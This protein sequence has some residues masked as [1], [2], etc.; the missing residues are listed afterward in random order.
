MPVTTLDPKTALVIIDLQKGI[1]SLPVPHIQEV[2]SHASALT[3]GFRQHQLPVVL[4]NV[5]D[6]PP[7]RTEYSRNA[8]PFPPDFAEIIADLQPQP[9]DH[10]VT[11]QTPGAFTNTDLEAYLKKMGITQIVIAGVATSNGVEATARHAFEL[12]FNISFAIDAIADINAEAHT[13]SITH[14]FPKLGEIGSTQ[15]IL[16]LLKRSA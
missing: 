4:V 11:K 14:I 5:T 7:G 6:R 16:D 9:Q 13:N 15:E 3:N 10:I 2:I 8:A 1:V 12:G